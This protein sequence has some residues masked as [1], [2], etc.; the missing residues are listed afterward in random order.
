[1]DKC[2][3]MHHLCSDSCLADVE[4]IMDTCTVQGVGRVCDV[5]TGPCACMTIFSKSP[6]T[7]GVESYAGTVALVMLFMLLK[8]IT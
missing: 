8:K 4:E 6:S 5:L 7:V 2:P 1:M 3:S